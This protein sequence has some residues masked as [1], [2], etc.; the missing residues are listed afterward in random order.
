MQ[1]TLTTSC[2]VDAA[3]RRQLPAWIRDGLEKME[4]DKQRQ[5]ERDR[6]RLQQDVDRHKDTENETSDGNAGDTD[7]LTVTAKSRF[8]CTSFYLLHFAISSWLQKYLCADV[9]AV[10]VSTTLTDFDL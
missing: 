6:Q 2:D 1:I 10:F 5:L 8:V 4:R 9:A 7:S 3:K